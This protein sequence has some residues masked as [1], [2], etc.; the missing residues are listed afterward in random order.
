MATFPLQSS[1]IFHLRL[2]WL[3]EGQSIN[4]DGSRFGAAI[5][6]NAA[7]GATVPLVLGRMNAISVQFWCEFEHFG[8]A[9]FNTEP[10]SFALF[11]IDLYV[12]TWL[13]CHYLPRSS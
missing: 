5:E 7:T 3:F 11:M 8:R 9:R 13:V 10:A 2:G 1:L 12:T 6:A 4:G